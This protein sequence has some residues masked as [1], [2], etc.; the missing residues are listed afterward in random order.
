[1]PTE[2]RENKNNLSRLRMFEQIF[3]SGTEGALIH[4]IEKSNANWTVSN[5][6]DMLIS[7][8]SKENATLLPP[9][10]TPLER[11]ASRNNTTAPP[12]LAKSK[13]RNKSHNTFGRNIRK[14]FRDSRRIS[15]KTKLKVTNDPENIKLHRYKT[16]HESSDTVSIFIANSNYRT[17][18][19]ISGSAYSNEYSDDSHASSGGNSAN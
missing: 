12:Q 14:S 5:F 18:K 3:D 19:D 15:R 16:L 1:M 9:E 7:L 6:E 10:A 11:T 8:S 17:T 2:A 13:S 4:Y